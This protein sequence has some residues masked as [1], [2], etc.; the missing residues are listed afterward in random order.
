MLGILVHTL[1]PST[2]KGGQ[3]D[4]YEFISLSILRALGQFDLHEILSQNNQKHK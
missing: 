4:L 3:M 1:D 2:W